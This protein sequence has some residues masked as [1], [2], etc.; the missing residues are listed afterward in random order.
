MRG[1]SGITDPISPA[2]L[3]EILQLQSPQEPPVAVGRSA[4]GSFD[5]LRVRWGRLQLRVAVRT[6]TRIEGTV[7]NRSITMFLGTETGSEGHSS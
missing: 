6:R 4:K 1:W 3:E 2:P 5:V 7:N